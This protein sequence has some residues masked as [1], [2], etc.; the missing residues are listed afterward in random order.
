MEIQKGTKEEMENKEIGKHE[1]VKI[2]TV[3]EKLEW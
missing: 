1:Q 3:R 2:L